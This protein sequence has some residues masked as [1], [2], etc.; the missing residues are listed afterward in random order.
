MI[1]PPGSSVRKASMDKSFE[2]L[3]GLRHPVIVE[4]GMT[5]HAD[6]WEG[7]G[8]S[9][10][11][12]AHFIA[13][14]PCGGTLFSI[15]IN[16][17][18]ILASDHLMKKYEIPQRDIFL[19]CADA[20]DFMHQAK[21]ELVDLLYLDAWDYGGD[22]VQKEE[23]ALHHLEA[24]QRSEKWLKSGSLVLIDDILNQDTLVGKGQY[25]IPHLKGIGYE[26]LHRG[27]QFLFR[28]P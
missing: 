27:Y 7:D 4:Y 20:M 17:Y 18:S 25:L 28:K 6:S 5:R 3:S 19:I 13:Q 16:P 14:Q 10:I 11:L 8:F 12:F 23:S 26:E 22:D 2:I 21:L 15:D 24:F 9:T 1:Q